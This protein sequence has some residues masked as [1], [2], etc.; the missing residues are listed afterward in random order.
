[1]EMLP[2]IIYLLIFGR[3][4]CMHNICN[5][6]NV[7][8]QQIAYLANPAGAQANSEHSSRSVILFGGSYICEPLTNRSFVGSASQVKIIIIGAFN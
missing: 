2:R 4:H 5:L 6:R 3:E 7:R 1:M 8:V